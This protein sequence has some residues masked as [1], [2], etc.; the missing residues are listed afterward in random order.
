MVTYYL[1]DPENKTL[2]IP[3]LLYGD[4]VNSV[5]AYPMKPSFEYL[6]S[7]LRL[8]SEISAFVTG[9][10]NKDIDVKHLINNDRLLRILPQETPFLTFVEADTD[11][12]D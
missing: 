4:Y 11:V 5:L 2:P 6:L 7:Y 10:L 1:N 9:K 12:V 8:S 3:F